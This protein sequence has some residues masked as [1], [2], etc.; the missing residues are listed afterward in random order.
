VRISGRRN[1]YFRACFQW[2]AADDPIQHKQSSQD[3]T[4]TNRVSK[5][6]KQMPQPK[7]IGV[8]NEVTATYG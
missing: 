6:Q 8:A 2:L 3:F 7:S 5:G 4:F 1:I